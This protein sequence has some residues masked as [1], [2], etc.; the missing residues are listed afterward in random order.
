MVDFVSPKLAV[1]E[2]IS[3][4][5]ISLNAA[6][7]PPLTSNDTMPPNLIRLSIGLEDPDDLIADIKI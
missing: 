2:N 1:I 5:L 3:T 4:A 7:F 6:A